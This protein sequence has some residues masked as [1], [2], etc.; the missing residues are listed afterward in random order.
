MFLFY[1]SSV[2]L[3]G[4]PGLDVFGV[5]ALLHCQ[6]AVK[7]CRGYELLPLQDRSYSI[8]SALRLSFLDLTTRIVSACSVRTEFNVTSAII[9]YVLCYS[10]LIR[11]NIVSSR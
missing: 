6:I 8:V 1:R 4:Y 5:V 11:A 2:Y 10:I 9:S 3:S 7:R